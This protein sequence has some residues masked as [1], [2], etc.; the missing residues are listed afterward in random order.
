MGRKRKFGR[1]VNG[2]LILN[3][4][5]A[6]TSNA[7][8]QQAK[9]LFFA[10][11]VGHT[12]SLD[13]LATG[14][15]PL[16]F[17]EATKFSQFLLDAD[18]AYKST[19]SFGRTTTTGDADG[20]QTSETPASDLTEN[21]LLQA[22]EAFKGD[23]Q[24]IPSMYSALKKN[25]KPLYEYARQGIEIERESR[26]V[27]VKEFSL[28]SFT[29]GPFPEASVFVECSKGTYVRSIA[30]D[31][32]AALGIGAH[33]K[34]L[35]RTMAGPFHERDAISIDQLTEERGDQRA[36]ILDHH[37]LPISAGL[38]VL[39]EVVLDEHS[40]FYLQQGQSVMVPKL[41]QLAKENAMVRISLDSGDFIGVGEVLEDGKLGPRRLISQSS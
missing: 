23:I 41:Y 12:G 33:V 39:P 25:G 35:H 16:C 28:L 31:I 3:K 10:S 17:G 21:R 37:L 38:S 19:F 34:T 15:L 2:I 11:K 18:K 8:L 30:E 9:R 27:T 14:V 7:E 32:G 5:T 6:V 36:E 4:S 26:K 1:Q 22:M 20:E 24:Q 13:P 40:G 29:A